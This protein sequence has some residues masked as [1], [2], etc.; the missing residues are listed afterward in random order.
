MP[1]VTNI[2]SQCTSFGGTFTQQTST[3]ICIYSG[4]LYTSAGAISG[5]TGALVGSGTLGQYLLLPTTTDAYN[6]VFNTTLPSSTPIILPMRLFT[7][8]ST[9]LPTTGTGNAS[10]L[11]GY[12]NQNWFSPIVT[13]LSQFNAVLNLPA[14][15]SSFT[16][17]RILESATTVPANGTISKITPNAFGDGDPTHPNINYVN[18]VELLNNQPTSVPTA[19]TNPFKTMDSSTVSYSSKDLTFIGL[20]NLGKTYSAAI[21]PPT[22]GATGTWATSFDSSS[23]TEFK[24]GY[25]YGFTGNPINISFQY[26]ATPVISG[27]NS[28]YIQNSDG[29][30]LWYS[31]GA[32]YLLNDPSIAFYGTGLSP[33]VTSDNGSG[34]LFTVTRITAGL[35]PLKPLTTTG[36]QPIFSI[37]LA[38]DSTTALPNFTVTPTST[39]TCTIAYVGTPTTLQIYGTASSAS[40]GTLYTTTTFSYNLSSTAITQPSFNQILLLPQ[41]VSSA[42][43]QAQNVLYFPGVAY[44]TVANTPVTVNIGFTTY[45]TTMSNPIVG[46]GYSQFLPV[47]SGS[48]Y[49]WAFTPFGT[50]SEYIISVTGTTLNME[51]AS[52]GASAFIA[53]KMSALAPSSPTGLVKFD[54]LEG[55]CWQFYQN[56]TGGFAIGSYGTTVP[57]SPG[58][59][60]ISYLTYTYNTT[61]AGTKA[62]S[63]TIVTGSTVP[64]SAFGPSVSITPNC[65]LFQCRYITSATGIKA[66]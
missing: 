29:Y 58:S 44:P 34:L 7:P 17:S 11:V 24:T 53:S 51:L 46:L 36:S 5:T 32:L 14:N 19:T 63:V 6:K 56:N 50:T 12:I 3:N 1:L 37:S 41:G 54:T 65:T 21:V 57:A 52:S 40:V 45:A 23:G 66:T 8:S 39:T 48:N 33:G 22:I 38:S 15:T 10:E 9:A 64:L 28:F 60:P 27:T 42:V 55:Y 35:N 43:E 62:S 2:G 13:S 31:G 4:W 16:A 26:N 20:P 47:N 25:F 18:Y 49:I 61:A 59:A 30:Y